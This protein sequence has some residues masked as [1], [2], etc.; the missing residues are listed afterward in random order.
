[1]RPDDHSE[2]AQPS[3]GLMIESL[4]AF[5]Y[6]L[7]TA[8]ADLIDNSIAARARNV[9]IDAVWRGRDSM[10][11]VTD[12]GR[13]MTPRE[14][15]DAMRL[16][17][18]GPLSPRDP[19]DLGRF[20]LGLKTASFSQCR[21]LTVYSRAAQDSCIE[22][23]CW[24]LDFVTECDEWRVLKKGTEA[25]DERSQRLRSLPTGTA[26]VWE[27]LD[28]VV[29]DA[30]TNNEAARDHF[31]AGLDGVKQHLSMVFHRFLAGP[32]ALAITLNERE[33]KAWDPFLQ[34]DS[35]TQRLPRE[36]LLGCGGEIVVTPFVLPHH[37]K[38]SAGT[39]TLAAGPKGWN[40]HQ[41]FYVYRNRRLLVP[42]DWLRL[43]MQKE[44]HY[45]LARIMLDIPNSM[46]SHWSLDVRKARAVPPAELRADLRR[47]AKLTRQDAAGV[48]RHRGKALARAAAQAYVFVWERKLKHGKVFYRINRS[49]PLVKR[50]FAAPTDIRDKAKALLRLLEET[51][52]LPLIVIDSSEQPDR[53][54]SPFEG[55][56]ADE[57]LAVVRAVYE[58]LTAQGVP[59]EEAAERLLAMEPFSRY[60]EQIAAFLDSL[61]H[62]GE[63]MP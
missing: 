23:R 53:H 45:K 52:P 41:R 3:P 6:D 12:D 48:Y 31:L 29:G 13:G 17:C 54:A 24:D 5:G 57:M 47:I 19:R 25:A 60:P 1:M 59:P 30:D 14:L 56:P 36:L 38:I 35:A 21:R 26:V 7:R 27:V 50:V 4:R 11:S 37:S 16:G 20:G 28:R 51:V 58:S 43:G 42:G 46:D 34:N 8:L 61:P 55:S 40:A 32:E 22:A 2:L 39:H 44:E 18:R 49:H 63:E 62:P 15:L 33:V 9:W 10:I